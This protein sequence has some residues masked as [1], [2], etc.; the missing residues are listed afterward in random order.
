MATHSSHSSYKVVM[1]DLL[2]KGSS[3]VHGNLTS[4]CRCNVINDTLEPL[5]YVVHIELFQ[6]LLTPVRPPV[7][8][9]QSLSQVQHWGLFIKPSKRRSRRPTGR[10]D[11]DINGQSSA[12]CS[13]RT[14]RW[15]A[16]CTE[17]QCPHQ[18]SGECLLP[19]GKCLW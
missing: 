19:T 7:T 11:D 13:R 15:S 1:T 5:A 12:S 9:Q 18:L 3:Y 2:Q 16:V 6:V 8:I 10:L 14:S 4:T 17:K